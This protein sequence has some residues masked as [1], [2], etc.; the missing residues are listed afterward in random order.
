MVIFH[1]CAFHTLKWSINFQN[2]F[3]HLMSRLDVLQFVNDLAMQQKHMPT[4]SIYDVD[5]KR[6][7]SQKL[8]FKQQQHTE[9]S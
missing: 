7:T 9:S 2:N 5:V 3:Q 4:H 8:Q 1:K 6:M